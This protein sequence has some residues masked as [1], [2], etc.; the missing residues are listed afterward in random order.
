MTRLLVS[1]KNLPEARRAAA[2]GV[3][4]LDLK[5]PAAGALGALTE[6]RIAAIVTDLRPRHPSLVISATV[7]DLPVEPAAA[8]LEKVSAVAQLGVDLVKVGLPARGGAQAAALLLAL[9]RSAQPIVPVLL[10]DDG[11]D[12]RFFARACEL[13]FRALMLDTER[14]RQGSL[15]ERLDHG[16]I[17]ALV[18]AARQAGKPLGLAGALRLGD[19]S[20]LLTL[21]PDFAGFRSAV[22]DHARSGRLNPA[23]IEALRAA[24]QATASPAV[25]RTRHRADRRAAM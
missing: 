21:A 17:A 2:V 5:D 25:P 20:E 23:R 9:A 4:S 22:C 16:E 6:T 8:V 15:L 7:G 3:D 1:V 10:A 24:L 11:V 12:L 18:S 14:K 19:I 13:P